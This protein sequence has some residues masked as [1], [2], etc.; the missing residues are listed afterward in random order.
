MKSDELRTHTTPDKR[1]RLLASATTLA[2][3]ASLMALPMTGSASDHHREDRSRSDHEDARRAL[4]SGKVLALRQ[5]LDIVAREYPG[6]PVE[7]EF[8]HDDGIYQYEIKLLQA[9]GR[10][11]KLKVDASDGRIISVKARDGKLEDDD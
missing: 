8:E 2:L 9:S 11:I 6:D 5:V 4:L 10:I 3:V 1:R 7:I